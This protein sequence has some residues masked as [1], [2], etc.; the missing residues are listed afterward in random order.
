MKKIPFMAA[1]VWLVWAFPL[2]YLIY[3]W[4]TLPTTVPV[5]F[6][7]NGEPDRMG[8]KSEMAFGVCLM[9]VLSV[10]IYFLMKYL[11][12]IDPKQKDKDTGTV[13]IKIGYAV[14][15]LLS[16]I[17]VSIIYSTVTT[18]LEFD[19]LLF[20]AL[21]IFFSY[22]GNIMYNMKPNYFAGIRTPWTLDNEDNWKSTHRLAGK[23]WF[24]GGIVITIGTLLIP[25]KIAFIFFMIIITIIT[26]IPIIYS[27]RYFKKHQS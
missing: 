7:I 25:V 23:L 24:G 12:K 4:P 15:L 18:K 27:Y 9:A 11:P 2:A 22:L 6:N 5:H 10:G 17:G 20:P 19:Y 16:G 1:F 8:S 3:I 26:L 21:G 14:I 13:F